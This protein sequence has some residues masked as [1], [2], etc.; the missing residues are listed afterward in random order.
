MVKM[1]IGNRASYVLLVL[2]ILLLVSISVMIRH[3]SCRRMSIIDTEHYAS[4][5][6]ENR[7]WDYF[8]SRAN[9]SP[10]YY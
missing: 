2:V 9:E 5:A 10:S 8:T 4:Y 3:N 1:N 6:D 7:T